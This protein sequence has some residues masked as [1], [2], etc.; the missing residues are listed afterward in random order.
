MLVLVK[1]HGLANVHTEKHF[2]T[3]KATKK[4]TG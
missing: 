2:F 4:A 3:C 1:P